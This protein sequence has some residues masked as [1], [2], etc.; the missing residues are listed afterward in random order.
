MG[1]ENPKKTTSGGFIMTYRQFW[2][3]FGPSGQ[4]K[5][6]RYMLHLKQSRRTAFW[7]KRD[8]GGEHAGIGNWNKYIK[9]TRTMLQFTPSLFQ[10]QA[11]TR[12]AFYI[13]EG[14]RGG[15][16]RWQG[17]VKKVE[18]KGEGV[19]RHGAGLWVLC[20]ECLDVSHCSSRLIRAGYLLDP[21]ELRPR[22][23]IIGQVFFLK[24]KSL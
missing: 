8:L 19:K 23:V 10:Q 22:H 3:R 2:K 14:R 24:Q 1:H 6:R 7:S 18:Y 4:H 5:W 16:I 21:L 13:Q 11:V 15:M 17:N 20:F 12:K 9:N